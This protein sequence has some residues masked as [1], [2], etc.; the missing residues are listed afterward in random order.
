MEK[1]SLEELKSEIKDLIK[2]NNKNFVEHQRVER[3][4]SNIIAAKE[5]TIFNLKKEIDAKDCNCHNY[6]KSIDEIYHAGVKHREKLVSLVD[7]SE[8]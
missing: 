5:E 6:S 4:L 8:E 2:V 7:I 3:D 1:K